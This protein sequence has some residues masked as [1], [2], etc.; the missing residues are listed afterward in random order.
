[1]G[2]LDR[3]LAVTTMVLP[4]VLLA[5]GCAYPMHLLNQARGCLSS[6]DIAEAALQVAQPVA[7]SGITKTIGFLSLSTVDIALIRDLALFGAIGV[8]VLTLAALTLGPAVLVLAPL[9]SPP[10]RLG[11]WLRG[12]VAKW[13]VRLASARRRAVLAAWMLTAA[14]VGFGLAHL[15][16]SSDVILWFPHGSEVRDSYEEI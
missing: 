4:S 6:S 8:F 15:R 7:L 12:P 13:L 5:L 3:P 1:M 10:D 16:V 2:A 14:I 11:A 9:A